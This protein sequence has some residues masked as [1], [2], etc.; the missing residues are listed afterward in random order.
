MYDIT[1]GKRPICSVIN[2]ILSKITYNNCH[3]LESQDDIDARQD[4][5]WQQAV[6]QHRHNSAQ[7]DTRHCH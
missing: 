5:H 4:D 7:S 3:L 6:A 1:K 2:E